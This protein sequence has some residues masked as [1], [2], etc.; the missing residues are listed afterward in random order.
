LNGVAPRLGSWL[1]RPLSSPLCVVGWCVASAVFIGVV[2]LLGGPASNDTYESVLSTWAIQHGQLAC[3]FPAGYKVTAPLY[4]LVSGGIAALEHVGSAVPFPPRAALGPHCDNAFL[5]I[6]TWSLHADAM[7]DTLRIAYLGWVVL[8]AGLVALLRSCGRGHCGWEPATLLLV[9]CLPPVWMCVENTFHPEDLVAMGLALAA[10][11]CA[12]RNS[13]V[14]AGVFVALACFSQQFAILVAASLLIVAPATRRLAYVA[15]AIA[16]AAVVAVPLLALSSGRAADTLFVG[17]GNTGG[18]GGTVLWELGL[19]GGAL[20]ALSRVTPI[21]LAVLVAWWSVSR[22][23]ASVRASAPLLA[24]VAISL[25][26]RLVFEQQLFGYYFMA[27][28]V[29]LVLLD[30]VRGHLRA[31]LVAWL[32]TVSMVYLLGSTALSLVSSPWQRLLDVLIPAAV[33][34]MGLALVV[35]QV[36]RND[37]N[38]MCVLWLGMVAA[39]LVSWSATD[40]I[41]TPPTWFWQVVLVPL[42][43]GLAA[44]PLL[45][46]V[47]GFERETHSTSPTTTPV[48]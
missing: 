28:A 12:R 40:V 38:W 5:A 15:A 19:H 43:L 8:L 23:G 3:A 34:L 35:R 46:A 1:S 37:L 20:L 39:A 10:V 18:V 48:S 45:E 31:S 17:T 47:H 2:A 44:A 42:G 14:T 29:T 41:G 9:A 6:N 27:M 22:L 11:A 7:P 4:P 13:W 16:S 26:L 33:I 36:A 21:V 25:G 30:V 24:V 32:A